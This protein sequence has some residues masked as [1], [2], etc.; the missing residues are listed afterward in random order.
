LPD[1][2]GTATVAADRW[3]E[4]HR[5]QLTPS[6]VDIAGGRMH[7]LFEGSERAVQS[8]VAEL[9]GGDA[10]PWD[11]LRSLQSRLPGRVRWDGQPA[12][13]ARPGRR[14]AYIENGDE[15]AWSALA[16]RVVEALC[17]PT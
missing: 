9:G 3:P 8:Q 13:L 11:E 7:V 10:D 6:A 15:A 14:V 12:P 17:S 16:E 2:S 5:S 4:L 1:A